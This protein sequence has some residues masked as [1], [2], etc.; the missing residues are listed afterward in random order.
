MQRERIRQMA[1]SSVAVIVLLSGVAIPDAESWF[2]GSGPHP[3]FLQG[4]TESDAA[5]WETPP[6]AEDVEADAVTEDTWL[7]GEE[8]QWEEPSM[9]PSMENLLPEDLEALLEHELHGRRSKARK[10]EESTPT[11]P[12][13]RLPPAPTHPN[14]LAT[15]PIK[16]ASWLTLFPQILDFGTVK[17]HEAKDLNFTITNNGSK[18]VTGGIN[19]DSPVKV[20]FGGA[21]TLA[22]GASQTVTLRFHPTDSGTY[23]AN[24]TV[25][26]GEGTESIS[27]KGI[28]KE[29]Y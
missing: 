28:A 11:D 12:L 24:A 14:P 18:T 16:A 4:G 13:V 22:P 21:F 15:P 20:V 6:D 10:V 7:E 27:L 3:V 2:N 23:L 17:V 19:V 5:Q 9:D 8:G 26:S 25:R 1:F 29:S